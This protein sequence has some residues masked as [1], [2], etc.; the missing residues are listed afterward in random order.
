MPVIYSIQVARF[1]LALGRQIVIH[2]IV[3][4]WKKKCSCS[5]KYLLTNEVR[6]NYILQNL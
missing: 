6:D 1:L 4:Y 2:N 5:K 3:S